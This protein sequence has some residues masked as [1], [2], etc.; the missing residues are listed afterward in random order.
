VTT[1]ETPEATPTPEI[2]EATPTPSPSPMTEEERKKAEDAELDK[3]AADN[4]VKRPPKINTKPFEDIAQKGKEM[5]DKGSL[6]LNSS[7]VDV[8]VTAERDVDGTLKPESVKIEGVANNETM[9]SLAAEFV[10]ALSESK[11]L[12]I[13]EGA[14]EVRMSLKLDGEKVSVKIMNDVASNDNAAKMATGYGVLL[15]AARIKKEG[16]DE[17]ELWKSVNVSSEGKQFVMTFEMPRDAAAKMI[18]E[19]LTKKAAAAASKG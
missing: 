19:K 11:V 1:A 7:N 17:G 3:L 5:V 10:N 14:G 8:S 18:I 15:L 4:G 6:D 16:T 13:L 12:A 2:A 9:S